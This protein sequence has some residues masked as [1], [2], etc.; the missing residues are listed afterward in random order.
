MNMENWE[1]E[2]VIISSMISFFGGGIVILVLFLF[3]E[4][5]EKW[6][7]LLWKLISLF[8]KEGQKKYIA[9]D[10]QGKVNE[11]TNKKLSQEIKNYTPVGIEIEWIEEGQTPEEFFSDNK[12]IIRMR[13]SENQNKNLVAASMA[14]VSQSLLRKAKKYISDSQ[15]ES[16][17]LF[18]VNKI[19]KHEEPDIVDQFIQN[20][21]F[22]MVDSRQKI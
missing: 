18:V 6:I 7:A 14:F 15:K 4:K 22:K 12:V 10:I 21:L 16:I 1:L 8:Y 2:K 9:H 19:L 11:F 20:F 13:K 5:V 3:P 17:D